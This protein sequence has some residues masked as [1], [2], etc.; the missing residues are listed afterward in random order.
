MATIEAQLAANLE[1]VRG[2]IR[3][4]CARAGRAP[5][6]VTLV[7][8]TKYAEL[9]WVRALP[10]LGVTDLGES[11]PQ[12]LCERAELLT[13]AVRW[14]LIGH[15]QRNKV[16]RV[17][18]LTV[19]VHS[20]D[21]WKLLDRIELLAAELN[22]RPRVL[23][24]VNVAGEASKDGFSLDE[25]RRGWDGVARYE[26]AQVA[27]LMTMA[28]F[29]E[30]P[31]AAR[32]VFRRLRELRDELAAQSPAGCSLPELSMGMSHDFETAIEEGA[33]IIRVGSDLFAGLGDVSS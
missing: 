11:R 14:H 22:L 20:V 9:D 4:A 28:P 32:P 7:A 6:A 5:E 19:C 13:A 15:L 2:R 31:A 27:G 1:R 17:L 12:Q 23:L 29:L 30:D 21:S 16:R 26:R 25:L 24:E 3:H 8:V 18:P 33:T 10:A